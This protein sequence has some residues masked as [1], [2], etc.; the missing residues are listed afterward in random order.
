MKHTLN[1]LDI[2][3]FLFFMCIV[4]CSVNAV[5]AAY[6]AYA[7]E[8]VVKSV[9]KAILV[10]RD[11]FVSASSMAGAPSL[12]VALFVKSPTGL[13]QYHSS[14]ACIYVCSGLA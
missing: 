11:D 10:L 1:K 4:C 7:A 6:A 3:G 14:L 13:S 12:S 9:P 5:D 8:N 2:E